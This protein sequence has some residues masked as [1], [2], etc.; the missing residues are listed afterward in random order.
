MF[1]DE[2]APREKLRKL[3]EKDDDDSAD[4]YARVTTKTHVS[5]QIRPRVTVIRTFLK[6]TVISI[7]ARAI[8]LSSANARSAK[9][10]LPREKGERNRFQS[11]ILVDDLRRI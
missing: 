7:E 4:N 8:V 9:R 10:D 3:A 2:S 5:E 1:G 6:C 11:K